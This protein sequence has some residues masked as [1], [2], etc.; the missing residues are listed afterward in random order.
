LLV[1][2]RVPKDGTMVD[3]GAMVFT[4]STDELADVGSGLG[5]HA[6]EWC[7]NAFRS[8]FRTMTRVNLCIHRVID[9]AAV[10]TSSR[11][12]RWNRSHPD[13]SSIIVPDYCPG[14]FVEAGWDVPSSHST[15]PLRE[16]LAV[17]VWPVEHGGLSR[18]EKAVY[19]VGFGI[20]FVLHIKQISERL[21]FALCAGHSSIGQC[22]SRRRR[23]TG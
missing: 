20:P 5:S 1:R 21:A 23:F 10:C 9:M 4:A 17:Y 11:Q 14:N 15:R 8:E 12:I 7:W 22:H 2:V 19:Q 16:H 6:F 18:E 13:S 3:D